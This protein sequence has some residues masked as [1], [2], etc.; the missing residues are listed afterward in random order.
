M[1]ERLSYVNRFHDF[2]WGRDTSGFLSKDLW[3][4]CTAPGPGILTTR[5]SRIGRVLGMD[6]PDV[7]LDK[8]KQAWM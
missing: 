4:L 7:C 8:Y 3:C 5:V 1:Q 2:L 6:P